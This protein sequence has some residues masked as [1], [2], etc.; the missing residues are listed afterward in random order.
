M[1]S[2]LGTYIIPVIVSRRTRSGDTRAEYARGL[3]GWTGW[4]D[5]VCMGSRAE[6]CVLGFILL[7]S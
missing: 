3:L 5:K 4:A 1:I 7:A 2:V 6:C